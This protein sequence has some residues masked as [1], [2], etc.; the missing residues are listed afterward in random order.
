[1]TKRKPKT[2]TTVKGRA[3]LRL[4]KAA[5]HWAKVNG[6]SAVVAGG[7]HTIKWPG[8]RAFNYTIGIKCTGIA[9][10]KGATS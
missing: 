7:I 5:A 10:T 4:L 8:E 3:T 6:G 2:P 1:M 9:P